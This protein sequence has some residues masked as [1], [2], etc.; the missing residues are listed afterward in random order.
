[1]T[2]EIPE[3]VVYSIADVRAIDQHTIDSGVAS[4]ELMKRAAHFALV[5]ALS[6]FPRAKHWV[7]L[8]GSGK[9]AGDGY[10]LANLAVAIGR[11]VDALYVTPPD[12]LSGDARRGYEEAVK[13]GVTVTRFD[14]DL[15][16]NADLI[17]DALLGSGL[18]R[19]IDGDFAAAAAAISLHP[20]PCLSLDI[21]TGIDGDSGIKLGIAVQADATTT[22]VGRK[23]GL[24]FNDGPAHAGQI[25]YS[26]LGVPAAAFESRR[27]VLEFLREYITQEA[28]PP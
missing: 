6:E 27:P 2:A 14:G 17:V 9:N 13:A 21:P 4:F 3:N 24:Y 16:E 20:A 5:T 7:V 22:F 23:T 10:M 8:C 18:N 15:H 19:A 1:M 26:D 28:L 12:Q 11:Q 25:F